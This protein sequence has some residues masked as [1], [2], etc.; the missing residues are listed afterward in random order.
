MREGGRETDHPAE[1]EHGVVLQQG[2]AE[3]AEE[4]EDSRQQEPSVCP[5]HGAARS[6][7]IGVFLFSVKSIC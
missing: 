5:E 7:A 3:D 1:G 4:G 6:S 2:L